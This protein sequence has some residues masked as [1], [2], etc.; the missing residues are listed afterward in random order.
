MTQKL[1]AILDNE[2]QDDSTAVGFSRTH[3]MKRKFEAI[4]NDE[5][6]D[7]DDAVGNAEE[8][9]DTSMCSKEYDV[10]KIVSSRYNHVCAFFNLST[11]TNPLTGYRRA[12]VGDQIRR[13]FQDVMGTNSKS[14]V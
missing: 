7:D 8:G 2:T 11:A 4:S 5:T 12:R 10:E 14:R 3:G 9:A 6:E 13:I 1:K